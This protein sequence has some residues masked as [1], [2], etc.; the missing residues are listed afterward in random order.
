M[1]KTPRVRS[2]MNGPLEKSPSRDKDFSAVQV[3]RKFALIAAARL[4]FGLAL[5]SLTAIR[6]G[7][8]FRDS[9]GGDAAHNSSGSDR[10]TRTIP[11]T[12]L[13][14]RARLQHDFVGNVGDGTV[15][16]LAQRTG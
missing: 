15:L 7:V 13:A 2:E 14:R 16:N 6:P 5:P 12:K 4:V 8:L 1:H 11:Q 9:N 10:A 3:V